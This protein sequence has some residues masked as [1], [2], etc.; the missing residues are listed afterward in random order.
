MSLSELKET[1]LTLPEVERHE[2]FVWVNRLQSGYADIPGEALD[3]LAA[4]IWDEDDRRA[5]PT[6][7]T[8]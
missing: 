5:A 1:V 8:R 3:R 7:P 2:F 4:E 6:H